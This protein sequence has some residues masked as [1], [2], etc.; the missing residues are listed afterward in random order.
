MNYEELFKSGVSFQDFYDSAQARYRNYANHA[1]SRNQELEKELEK[2]GW[3]TDKTRILAIA[4]NWCIDSVIN[5]PVIDWLEK[6]NK[7]IEL[8]IL[9]TVR[10]G[11]AHPEDKVLTPTLIILDDNYDEVGRWIQY[12]QVIKQVV[13]FGDQVQIIVT[14]KKYRQ[15]DHV[16]DTLDEVLDLILSRSLVH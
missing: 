9:D 2:V 14:K 5:L 7:N 8:R 15:G 1:I 11:A 6:H 16:M 12:P 13:D 10:Y 4:E 3:I